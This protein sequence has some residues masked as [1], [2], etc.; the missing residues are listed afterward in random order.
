MAA[1]GTAD[2]DVARPRAA[3]CMVEEE[4]KRPTRATLSL[5][6]REAASDRRRSG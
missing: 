2:L 4:F 6:S 1:G 5:T 3:A